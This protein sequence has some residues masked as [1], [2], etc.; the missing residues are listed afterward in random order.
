MTIVFDMDNTLVDELGAS[1]RPGIKALLNRLKKENHVLVLWTNSTRDRALSIMNDHDLRQFFK[2]M[3]FRENY[4]PQN[5]GLNKDIRKVKGDML[6]DDDPSEIS[7]V[8]SIKK[9]GFEIT[10]Y[11]KGNVPDKRELAKLYSIIKSSGKTSYSFILKQVG[12]G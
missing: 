12:F 6:V 3:I 2:M 9:K 1:V 7:F 10:P 11:R 8:I 5:K 4:D